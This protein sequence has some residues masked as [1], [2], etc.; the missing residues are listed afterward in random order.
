MEFKAPGDKKRYTL[1]W[2]NDLGAETIS[3]VTW[4][5]DSGITNESESNDTTTSTIEISSGTL[6]YTYQLSCAMTTSTGDI[7][8]KDFSLRVQEHQAG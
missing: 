5:I 4:T 1:D 8:V 2:S 6:G 7:H 3:A